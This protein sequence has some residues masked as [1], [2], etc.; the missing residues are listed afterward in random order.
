MDSQSLEA[1]LVHDNLPWVRRLASKLVPPG[2]EMHNDLLQEGLMAMTLAARKFDRSAGYSFLTYATPRIKGAMMDCLR[3]ESP[4]TRSQEA[5]LRKASP[6]LG[7]MPAEDAAN[8]AGVDIGKL[9]EALSIK[10]GKP[11]S[12]EIQEVHPDPAM[13][14]EEEQSRLRD[15]RLLLDALSGLSLQERQVMHW[16]VL[17]GERLVDVAKYLC[18]SKGAVVKIK[19]SAIE[20]LM[21]AME[22]RND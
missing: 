21:K 9:Q 12:P 17:E 7:A 5:A 4:L 11:A 13:Q 15:E 10:A 2:R 14:V 20:R 18:V 22:A 19:Q 8:A 16:H 1:S 3:K 6:M